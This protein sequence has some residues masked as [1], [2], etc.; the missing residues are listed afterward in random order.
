VHRIYPFRREDPV[1]VPR[2]GAAPGAVRV[3]AAAHCGEGTTVQV[4][5]ARLPSDV[6]LKVAEHAIRSIT[7]T[8]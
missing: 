7:D 2:A 8:N 6:D 1:P 5:M 4:R 3:E